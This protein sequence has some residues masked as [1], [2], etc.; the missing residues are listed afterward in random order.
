[1]PIEIV[2]GGNVIASGSDLVEV[3]RLE[4]GDTAKT[5]LGSAT[6]D[7][8]PALGDICIGSSTFTVTRPSE[9]ICSTPGRAPGLTRRARRSRRR[10]ATP[11]PPWSRWRARSRPVTRPSPRRSGRSMAASSGSRR[12][13]RR[14]TAPR[15]S[16]PIARRRPKTHGGRRE[17]RSAVGDARC[18]PAQAARAGPARPRSDARPSRRL[19][20]VR[21]RAAEAPGTREGHRQRHEDRRER[22]APRH[23]R[24]ERRRPPPPSSIRS[25]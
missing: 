21:N 18:R 16:R 4:P 25:A 22:R 19:H 20:A 15:P 14:G 8:N 9:G 12:W 23:G 13:S 6:Y 17:G 2:R 3:P 24:A 10:P 7:G 5:A 1:M 11:R